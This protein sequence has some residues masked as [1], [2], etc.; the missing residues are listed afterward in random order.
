MKRSDVN[1]DIPMKLNKDF[2]SALK[3]NIEKY[4]SDFEDFN[5][6][7]DKNLNFSDFIDSFTSNNT[8][9]A[10]TSIDANANASTKDICGLLSEKGKPHDKIFAFNKIFLEMKQ[11]YGLRTARE[12]LESEYN[13]AYYLHDA[14]SATYKPYCYAYD[15]SRLAK[16]GLFFLQNNYNAE[17]PKHLETFID[18]TIEYISF[19]S[20]RSS[21][22]V[23]IPNVLIWTYYF[24][25]KDLK[26]KYL[27]I[28]KD[29]VHA[30]PYIKQ[31]F[32]KLIYRLNQPF[33]RVDQTA[34]VNVSIF[35]RPYAESLFG[36]L[37]YP[38][39][40]LFIDEVEGFMEHQKLFME[41]VSDIRGINMFTFPVLT[42]S[43]LY[44]KIEKKD[45]NAELD[46]L[47]N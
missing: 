38:D 1:F 7:A 40:T 41:V 27:G 8:T 10:D 6:F 24:W 14:P 42:F 22:A 39:G 29:S 28:D 21:G 37:E 44:N 26:D 12:W 11:T 33:M 4:G 15:L 46:K 31:A 32:Q 3:V 35:D 16:E 18:D 30:I 5:G 9:N 19:M 13:G 43:C 23:G 20:N 36:G 17:P 47:L 34:F 45:V 25:Q 2:V